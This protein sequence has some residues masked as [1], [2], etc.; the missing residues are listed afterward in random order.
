MCNK[1]AVVHSDETNHP[2]LFSFTVIKVV[3][4]CRKKKIHIPTGVDGHNN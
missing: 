3:F 2:T 1:K 4:R